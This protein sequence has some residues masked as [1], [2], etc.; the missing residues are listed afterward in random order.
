MERLGDLV[1]RTSLLA[2]EARVNTPKVV[3]LS[4]P[5]EAN[6]NPAAAYETSVFNALLRG[7]STLGIKTVNQCRNVRVDGLLELDDGRL[8]ALEI[9]YR[10][11]WPKACQACAQIIWFKSYPPTMQYAL[12]GGVVVF[13]EFSGDW[14]RRKPKWVLENGWNY[15]LTDHQTVEGLPVRLLKFRDGAFESYEMALSAARATAHQSQMTT[16]AAD[17]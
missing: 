5:M 11:N 8:L 10:M 14:A 4:G 2:E 13:E 17:K 9:K 15:W 16:I 12:A 7:R 6:G 1:D 3:A